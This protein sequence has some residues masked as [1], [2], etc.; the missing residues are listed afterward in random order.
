MKKITSVVCVL[1]ALLMVLSIPV[2]AAQAYTTY[3]YSID[4]KPLYSPDAYTAEKVITHTTMGVG[5]ALS[6]V[7]DMVTDAKGNVYIADTDNNR[8]ICLDKYFHLRF[9]IKDFTNGQGIADYFSK[10]EGVFVTENRYEGVDK[11]TGEPILKYKGRIF[12]CDT[13]QLY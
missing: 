5:T 1:F 11:E 12:V 9:E 13:S 2:G 10:P 4:G 7:S 3:T 6:N 8:I